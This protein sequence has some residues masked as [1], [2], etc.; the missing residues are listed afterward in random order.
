[1]NRGSA[2]F[3]FA[4]I[5]AIGCAAGDRGDRGGQGE[6]AARPAGGPPARA[7][8]GR[9]QHRGPGVISVADE[10]IQLDLGGLGVRGMA[11]SDAHQALLI[12]GGP[13]GDIGPV[14]LF[15]WSG[16]PASA[17]VAVQ[18][19]VSPAGTAAEAVVPYPGTKDVQILFDSGGL[20]IGGTEC[21]KLPS[22]SRSFT[23]VIVHV[24]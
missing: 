23:D 11:W 12:I 8:G 1:V 20:L 6:R 13:L 21:K 4:A 3:V 19:L 5:L 15:K 17:P 24:E 9:D 22:S 18:D 16:D 10:A 2:P 7:R 14:R